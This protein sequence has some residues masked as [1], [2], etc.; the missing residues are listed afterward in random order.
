M[1]ST[2]RKAGEARKASIELANVT[3]K[4]KNEA[5]GEVAKAIAKSRR[6][7][8]KANSQDMAA[9]RKA[10]L[11]NVLLK[12]LEL[13]DDK[14]AELVRS[15]KSVARLED[16]TG[17]TLDSV[18]L[19]KNLILNK[20][21]TPIGVIGVIFESRPEV[22][23]Q[24]ASLC[25]KSGNAVIL[26]GGSEAKHSNKILYEIMRKAS[27]KADL[28]QGWVQLIETRGEVSQMLKLN[29]YIDLL[30]PRGSN[31]FVKYVQ[32]HT[33]IPVLGHADG[34]CHAYVD[35]NAKLRKAWNV[36]LDSKVQYPAVCNAIETLLVHKDIATVFLA[37][38]AQ[39][40]VEHD[41]EIR[42]D[43]ESRQ[44]LNGFKVKKASEKDWNT[45]YNDLII[46]I[47]V[48]SNI[49][50]AIEHINTWGSGHTDMIVTEDKK[51]AERFLRFVDS[52]SVMHN[53]S[54]R[55]ADGFRY[56]F[57]AEVGIS[58]NKI[59]SRGPVGLEG[60]TI[61]KYVLKGDGHIVADYVGKGAKKY[62]HR[63]L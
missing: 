42:G 38:M 12:R 50:D 10:G 39:R 14:I 25:M 2:I 44:I 54:T 36:C 52:S 59:H 32:T 58:T 41:V 45:E 15:V 22:G 37:E 51:A 46:S 24:V 57:G 13:T 56:G 11:S 43:S 29:E 3:T 60:L 17:R 7:I 31:R 47:K 20:I 21:S 18:E 27:S 23:V 34:I 48:V 9:A 55:F 5:L 33:K 62:T 1:S 16:P 35:K 61:Y 40:Y 4:I 49:D 53:C 63:R 28:P 8:L 19:D 26:K 6:R 30:I